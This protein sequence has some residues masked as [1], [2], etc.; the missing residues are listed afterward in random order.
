MTKEGSGTDT[1]F[2]TSR[3][4]EVW[5]E[6]DSESTTFTNTHQCERLQNC[7]KNEYTTYSNSQNWSGI[8]LLLY[9]HSSLFFMFS[10]FCEVVVGVSG[11]KK[12]RKNKQAAMLI[13]QTGTRQHRRHF[14]PKL[15]SY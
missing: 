1:Q 11:E 14:L 4:I 5:R 7:L 13:K 9:M 10:I 15:I 2:I 8:L 12:E 3:Q 6:K